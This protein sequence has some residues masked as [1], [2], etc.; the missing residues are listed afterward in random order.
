[1]EKREEESETIIRGET[2]GGERKVRESKVMEERER[3]GKVGEKKKKDGEGE[4]DK[5]K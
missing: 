1:M 2:D 5:K 4:R 3:E